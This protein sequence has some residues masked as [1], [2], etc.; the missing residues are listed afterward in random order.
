MHTAVNHF[1]DNN[2]M[3]RDLRGDGP[4][5][6]GAGKTYAVDPAAVAR[7]K[8]HVDGQKTAQT[9]VPSVSQTAPEPAARGE[10]P[11]AALYP[12]AVIEAAKKQEQATGRRSLAKVLT[13]DVLAI[14]DSWN[15]NEG[16]SLS[17]IG[18]KANNQL[19]EVAAVEVGRYLRK[20]RSR[21]AAG[22]AAETAVAQPAPVQPAEPTAPE[23]ALQE[24]AVTEALPETAAEPFAVQKPKDLPTWLDRDYAPLRPGA[25]QQRAAARAGVGQV[26]S[27]NRVW[28]VVMS[29]W[30][31]FKEAGVILGMMPR[32]M[33][34]VPGFDQVATKPGAPYRGKFYNRADLERLA[35]YRNSGQL[36]QDSYADRQANNRTRAP[37]PRGN[38]KKQLKLSPNG[39]TVDPI[40]YRLNRATIQQQ[41]EAVRCGKIKPIHLP[42]GQAE[43]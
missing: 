34:K 3:P 31:T 1:N 8:A 40:T 25:G 21:R 39:R 20:Y 14:W 28:G 33:R 41:E 7:L 15:I 16:M 30:V 18:Q 9:A 2:A 37:R 22:A 17:A 36:F 42:I 38:G 26:K 12:A 27:G 13:D 19:I 6:A 24:T 35:E 32:N 5:A 29:D 23:A 11:T 43:L 4:A 10:Q